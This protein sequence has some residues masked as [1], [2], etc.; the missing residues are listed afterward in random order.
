MRRWLE[1]DN[2]EVRIPSGDKVVAEGGQAG[3]GG[4]LPGDLHGEPGRG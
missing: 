2:K 1:E 4:I 3:L